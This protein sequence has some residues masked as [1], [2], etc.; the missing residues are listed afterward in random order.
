MTQDFLFSG[1]YI[2]LGQMIKVLNILESGGQVKYFLQEVAIHI[3]GEKEQR[4]G[5]KLREGDLVEIE[6]IGTWKMTQN[7]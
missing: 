4:R 7:K 2:T 6:N 3:N 5:R 1:E